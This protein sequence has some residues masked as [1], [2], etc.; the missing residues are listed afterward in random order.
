MAD[1]PPEN[2]LSKAIAR[3]RRSRRRIID[4]TVSNP[5]VVGLDDDSEGSGRDSWSCP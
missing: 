2:R 4:L 5:T 1:V 3:A